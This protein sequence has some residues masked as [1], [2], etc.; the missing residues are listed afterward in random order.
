[1]PYVAINSGVSPNLFFA[2]SSAPASNARWT[3][4]K[5]RFSIACKNYSFTFF[6]S[7]SGNFG[8]FTGVTAI[9][10]NPAASTSIV[11]LC[12][13]WTAVQ[14]PKPAHNNILIFMALIPFI[15]VTHSCAPLTQFMQFFSHNNCRRH[16]CG[17]S[18][19]LQA[20]LNKFKCL[21]QG[22]R[23]EHDNLARYDRDRHAKQP[24]I[25]EG[26]HGKYRFIL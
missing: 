11:S 25:A 4:S 3:P 7:S 8:F 20:Q 6:C 19:L 14:T 24:A 18:P 13:D 1:M 16:G 10:R 22:R 2:S 17:Y 21:A 9:S 26:V 23:S 5:S 12:N 15:L